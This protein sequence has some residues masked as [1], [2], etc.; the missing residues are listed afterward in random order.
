MNESSLHGLSIRSVALA[1]D[2]R[3]G[4]RLTGDA[5][6][7]A[8]ER[9]M[10]RAES[11]TWFNVLKPAETGAAPTPANRVAGSS[12]AASAPSLAAGAVLRSPRV[13]MRPAL[14][15]RDSI[16]ATSGAGA[17]PRQSAPEATAPITAGT[18]PA[19]T[20]RATETSP[21]SKPLP[22]FAAGPLA[23]GVEGDAPVI[24]IECG[25]PLVATQNMALAGSVGMEPSIEFAAETP[26]LPTT[27]ARL[28]PVIAPARSA[29]LPEASS[30]VPGR[31]MEDTHVLPE[32]GAAAHAP[33]AAALSRSLDAALSP[34]RLHI[35]WSGSTARV[36]IGMDAP[37]AAQ[38]PTLVG[39]LARWLERS[40]TRL[41][42][43]TCNGAV[44]FSSG[45]PSL[46]PAERADHPSARPSVDVILEK[47][48]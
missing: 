24:A 43:V 46:L 10:E 35:E 18:S 29:Q 42:S 19:A 47:E 27:D 38:L 45:D 4:D 14:L 5:Q 41:R 6:R 11:Q 37:A 25:R 30:A 16:A 40:G 21:P 20:G 36:W 23:A 48:N 26:P 8:W 32:A 3:S 22:P 15:A 31:P 28:L 33:V 44:L 39:D 17:A 13:E 34:V 1:S 12:G 9:E 2:P 7:L